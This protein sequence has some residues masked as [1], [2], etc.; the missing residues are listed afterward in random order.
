MAIVKHTVV[1]I[2]ILLYNYLDPT[3]SHLVEP[4]VCS[5]LYVSHS[6]CLPASLSPPIP[7]LTGEGF[8]AVVAWHIPY[9]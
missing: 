1:H 4:D 2:V 7:P 6:I 8:A 3:E 5:L 9:L